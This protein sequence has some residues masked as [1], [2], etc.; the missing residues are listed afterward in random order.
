MLSFAFDLCRKMR[1]RAS[2]VESGIGLL[3]VV[4][5]DPV[6]DHLVGLESV[7]Q[8]VQIDVPCLNDRHSVQL[9]R[10]IHEGW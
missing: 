1:R 4:E 10:I 7:L 2:F 5:S 9:T 8:F 3:G 6:F